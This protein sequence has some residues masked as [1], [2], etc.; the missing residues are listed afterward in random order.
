MFILGFVRNV[1][2]WVWE[3][4]LNTVNFLFGWIA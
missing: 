1:I 2:L 4:F 3:L